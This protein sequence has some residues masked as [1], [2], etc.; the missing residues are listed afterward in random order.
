MLIWL[1]FLID[2]V[3]LL[4]YL[5]GRPRPLILRSPRNRGQISMLEI[6]KEKSAGAAAKKRGGGIA[7]RLFSLLE[8]QESISW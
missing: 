1:G 8:L 4:R 5:Y 2:I 3:V 7:L 6:S